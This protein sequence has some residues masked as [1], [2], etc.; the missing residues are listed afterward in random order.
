MTFPIGPQR[1]SGFFFPN[2]GGGSRNGAEVSLPYYWNIRPNADFMAEPVYYA[3]RGVDLAGEFRYLTKRQRGTLSFNYL[4]DDSEYLADNPLADS[5]TRYRAQLE[6][7]AELPG[8]WRFRIDATDVSDS[9]YFE[10]F[11]HGITKFPFRIMRLEF[12]HI[13]DP[14][15]VVA[16]AVRFL[17]G[18][19]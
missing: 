15:D 2:I 1:Q 18:P 17:I 5:S 19:G 4:P 11:A 14:P 12:S 3:K 6:H 9:S 16:D 13:A 7:V 8:D 10:D